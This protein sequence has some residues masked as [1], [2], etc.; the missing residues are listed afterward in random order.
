MIM[1][2]SIYKGALGQQYFIVLKEKVTA[3]SSTQSWPYK[4]Q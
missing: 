3:E 1:Y 4:R 2:L